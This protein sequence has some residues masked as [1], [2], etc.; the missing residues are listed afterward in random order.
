MCRQE[1]A[2][3]DMIAGSVVVC[4]FP[5]LF[6]I[7]WIEGGFNFL[8][9]LSYHGL[10]RLFVQCST[11]KVPQVGKWDRSAATVIRAAA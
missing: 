9:H 11:R 1:P 10:E 2:K 6:A 5:N 8:R 3:E 4:I 7:V